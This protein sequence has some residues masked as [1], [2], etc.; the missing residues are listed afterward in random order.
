LDLTIDLFAVKL[1]TRKRLQAAS[2]RPTGM[3]AFAHSPT[4]KRESTTT[5]LADVVAITQLA[6]VALSVSRL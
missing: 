6:W 2:R 5:L 3:P 4:R 1:L